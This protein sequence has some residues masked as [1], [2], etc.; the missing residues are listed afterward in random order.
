MVRNITEIN[1]KIIPFFIQ[2]P[3]VG[4]KSYEFEKFHRPG[5]EL[6]LSFQKAILVKKFLIEINLLKWL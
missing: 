1:N 2:Y 5:G 6:N 4:T 3:L